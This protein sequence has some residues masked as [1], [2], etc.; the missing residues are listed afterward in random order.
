MNLP[1]LALVVCLV[2]SK[3]QWVEYWAENSTQIW[4]TPS[5]GN[6]LYLSMITKSNLKK[7]F[8]NAI[9]WS[10]AKNHNMTFNSTAYT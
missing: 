6:I 3:F 5:T 8:V 2:S 9:P 10:G 7:A 4:S 1:F